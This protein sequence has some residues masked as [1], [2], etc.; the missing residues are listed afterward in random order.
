M[1]ALLA[2]TYPGNVRELMN[3]SER[4]VVMAEGR[5]INLEDLPAS[6]IAASTDA[7]NGCAAEFKPGATLAQ[8]LQA[9][10]RRILTEARQR[11]SSQA[12]MAESLQVNQSTIARKLKKYGLR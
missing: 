10:E 9:V 4:M 3:L 8:M 1:D 5:R 11:H 6:V 2:Y 12:Q 7:T